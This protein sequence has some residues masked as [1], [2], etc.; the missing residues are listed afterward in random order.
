MNL[1]FTFSVSWYK[2]RL[3]T[4]IEVST[5]TIDFA[6][7]TEILTVKKWG[8]LKHAEYQ[9]L[10]FSKCFEALKIAFKILDIK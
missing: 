10:I 3:I 4:S 8:K 1:H 2:T 6:L 9:K 5:S 7:Y